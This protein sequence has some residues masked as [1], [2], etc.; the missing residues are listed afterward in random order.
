MH[1]SLISM[2]DVRLTPVSDTLSQSDFEDGGSV[3][4]LTDD[5][6]LEDHSET[7]RADR[8]L[9]YNGTYTKPLP[10]QVHNVREVLESKKRPSKE[11][12]Q[13]ACRHH[14][15][16]DHVDNRYHI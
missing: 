2:Q 3:T 8:A 10:L 16:S 15:D 5:G 9:Q 13:A 6:V 4:K 12:Q 14:C 7:I 1:T 11:L